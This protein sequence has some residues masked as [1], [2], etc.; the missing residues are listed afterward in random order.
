[1]RPTVPDTD[2]NIS[3]ARDAYVSL[4]ARIE[5]AKNKPHHIDSPPPQGPPISTDSIQSA[6][7]VPPAKKSKHVALKI[8]LL[9]LILLVAGSVFAWNYNP[10]N[11]SQNDLMQVAY[12]DTIFYHPKQW[13]NIAAADAKFVKYGQTPLSNFFVPKQVAA[14]GVIR[15]DKKLSTTKTLSSREISYIRS[16]IPKLKAKEEFMETMTRTTGFS[17]R[18]KDVSQDY[19]NIDQEESTMIELFT[20]SYDCL[21]DSEAWTIKLRIILGKNDGYMRLAI[22]MAPVKQWD[23]NAEVFDRMLHDIKEGSPH[24]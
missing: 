12:K 17:C 9:I 1:M 2:K 21:H 8:V 20:T 22:L 3:N 23:Q 4:E 15:H 16:E 24:T 11:I 6:Y 19:D 7:I 5:A 10:T 13:S 18:E 14:F